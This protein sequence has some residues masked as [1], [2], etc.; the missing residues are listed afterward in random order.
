MVRVYCFVGGIYLQY[1]ASWELA[2]LVRFGILLRVF[3]VEYLYCTEVYTGFV[4]IVE[5]YDTSLNTELRRGSSLLCL[6][7]CYPYFSENFFLGKRNSAVYQG[8]KTTS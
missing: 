8:Q 4:L 3:C 1:E 5:Q 2:G 7:V 6:F